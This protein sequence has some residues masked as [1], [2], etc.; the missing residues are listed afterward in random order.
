MLLKEKISQKE[1]EENGYVIL[2]LLNSE[3]LAALNNL[4]NQ[5]HLNEEPPEFIDNIHMT[6]WCSNSKY[7]QT[8]KTKLENVFSSITTNFF[9]NVRS[10][11]HV[12]IV[13]RKGPK[14][15]FKVHQDWNV[16][17][18]AK[19]QSVN[20]WVPLHDVDK[21]GGALWV[22]KGS[23][24]INRPV[25]GAGYLFPDYSTHIAEL[26]KVAVSVKLKAGQAIIFYHSIIHGSPPN[27]ATDYRKAACFTVI[28][29]EAPLCIYFQKDELSKLERHEPKDD[30]MFNY[31]HLRTET[32]T[33]PPTQDPFIFKEPYI[34][35]AVSA[36]EVRNALTPRKKINWLFWK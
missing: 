25:R 4:Y 20:V 8:V 3:E 27:L 35:R 24:K 32:Y 1:L 5:I 33:N 12:F 16:V 6:I 29:K 10:L 31:N 23:H 22:I 9:E 36:D 30:F 28:P 34:N 15:T 19:Y 2:D 11:N 18:E 7:K 14:T 21:D 17:D 13:K 26:E